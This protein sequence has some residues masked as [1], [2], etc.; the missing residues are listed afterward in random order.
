MLCRDVV[1]D[2]SLGSVF[3]CICPHYSSRN[4]LCHAAQTQIRK[5]SREINCTSDFYHLVK[6]TNET[7][8]QILS[9]INSRDGFPSAVD[10]GRSEFGNGSLRISRRELSNVAIVRPPMGHRS[11]GCGRL[12]RFH[13]N[14][15]NVVSSSKLFNN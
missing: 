12:C 8:L 5:V 11:N 2:V 6:I 10:I 13:E 1:P 4:L 7:L 14:F 9:D 15:G 3:I